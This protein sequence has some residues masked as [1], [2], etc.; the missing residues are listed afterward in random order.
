MCI[1]DSH[2]LRMACTANGREACN[3]KLKD[4]LSVGCRSR[5]QCGYDANHQREHEMCIRDRYTGRCEVFIPEED[6]KE[7][8]KKGIPVDKAYISDESGGH[9]CPKLLS[10]IHISRG[11]HDKRDSVP[12]RS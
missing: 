2:Q 9:S 8:K 7:F 10:L 6:V 1:R 4:T 11:C 5:G 3:G 12:Y